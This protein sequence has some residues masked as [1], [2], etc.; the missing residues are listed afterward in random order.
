MPMR[1]NGASISTARKLRKK[2]RA[3]LIRFR[4]VWYDLETGFLGRGHRRED[5]PTLEIGAVDNSGRSFEQRCDP[6]RGSYPPLLKQADTMRWWRK[7][8]KRS[9]LNDEE[10][11]AYTDTL[12][13]EAGAWECFKE[14]ILAPPCDCVV[15]V[16]HNGKSFDHKIS[17][18]RIGQ[19]LGDNV[20]W[21][22]SIHILKE[23]LPKRPSYALKDL[24]SY[25]FDRRMPNHH[26]ALAD[27]RHL[28]QVWRAN[29]CT[30]SAAS[31]R[32]AEA[33]GRTIHE[34]IHQAHPGSAETSDETSP[35]TGAGASKEKETSEETEASGEEVAQRKSSE[36]ACPT[37]LPNVTHA[38][39]GKDGCGGCFRGDEP[40]TVLYGVGK[41]TAAA[42]AERGVHDMGD[43]MQHRH[44][45]TLT[46]VLAG[47]HRCHATAR[48]VEDSWLLIDSPATQQ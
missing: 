12:P 30:I 34:T 33:Y 11:R 4:Y 47:L 5:L 45:G 28:R 40:V 25:T 41:K 44:D 17:A 15:M 18:N 46:E 19:E 23:V 29:H 31:Q 37:R 27:A 14:W 26:T 9:K 13:T 16:A 32:V 22:D 42:L 43:M 20:L 3:P 24:Y 21:V 7:L 10:F 48:I 1:A 8:T 6:F 36:N 39:I 2:A 35:D 38:Y